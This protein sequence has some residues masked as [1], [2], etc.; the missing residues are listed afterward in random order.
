[1]IGDELRQKRDIAQA[2]LGAA[3][4]REAFRPLEGAVD[5]RQVHLEREAAVEGIAGDQLGDRAVQVLTG[6]VGHFVSVH[7][8]GAEV[9]E[10]FRDRPIE[11]GHP[12]SA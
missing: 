1:M 5:K 4:D 7:L 3:I 12:G 9:S 8:N 10:L 11:A 6:G 2:G